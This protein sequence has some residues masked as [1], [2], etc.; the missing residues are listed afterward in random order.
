MAQGC[1]KTGQ[2][3]TNAMFLMTHNKIH[4]ALA[5]KTFLRRQILSLIIGHTRMIHIASASLPG[6]A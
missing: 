3:G 2:K 4:H 1:N 6:A 5:A